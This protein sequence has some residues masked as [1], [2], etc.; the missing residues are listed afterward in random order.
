[1][2]RRRWTLR[3]SDILEAM[4]KIAQYTEGMTIESFAEDAKTF[5]AVVRNL[6]IIGEAATHLPDEVVARHPQ[7]PKIA[8]RNLGGGISRILS[9]R[10]SIGKYVRAFFAMGVS[11]LYFQ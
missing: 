6:E 9:A 8:S 10:R 3:I 4:V 11:M 1:M 5:D 2:S 7:I